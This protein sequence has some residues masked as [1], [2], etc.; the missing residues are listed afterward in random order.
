MPK[1][2]KYDNKTARIPCYLKYIKYF[3]ENYRDN[4]ENSEVNNIFTLQFE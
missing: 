2:L 1:F 3:H 4:H